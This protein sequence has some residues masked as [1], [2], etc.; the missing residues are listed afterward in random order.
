MK[1]RMWMVRAGESAYLIDD[2]LEKNIVAIGWNLIGPLHQFD[3]TQEIKTKLR[4]EYPKYKRGRVTISAS[5]IG[6][7]I[8]DFKKEDFVLTYNPEERVYPVGKIVSDYKYDPDKCEYNNIRKVN[9][10]GEVKRDNLATSSRN[11]LGAI[12]TIFEIKGVTKNEILR[13]VRG[14]KSAPTVSEETSEE[15]LD[16]LKEDVIEKAREF[17]KDKI[18]NLD[19][20]DMEELVAGIFRG[21][22]YKTRITPKGPDRGKD[23]LAS[24]D[25]LGLEE[26]RIKVEVKHRQG[27]IN[28][29]KLRS[30]IAGLSGAKGVYVSTG[31]FTKE[32]KYEAERA[33]NPVT[34][35]NIEGIVSLVTQYYDNFDSDTRSLLPLTKIYWPT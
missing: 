1:E 29:D 13:L 11:T 3:N 2:F 21:M 25:G 35:V 17:I 28:S 33:S 10:I 7:F 14:E 22:G 34:L 8:F 4:K 9:W 30:F 26:P 6:K 20:D 27:K 23:I 31:G 5:Q 32:A 12:S 19:W 16:T 18:T 24:P 15:E